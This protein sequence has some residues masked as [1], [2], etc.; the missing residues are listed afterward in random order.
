MPENTPTI[1]VNGTPRDWSPNLTV[2]ALLHERGVAPDA[3]ATALNGEFVARSARDHTPLQPG[4]Q[5][6]VFQAIVGG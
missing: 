3:A 1:T 4:D 5:L 2:A 6:T